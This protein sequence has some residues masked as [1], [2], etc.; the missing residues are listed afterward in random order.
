L[1]NKVR[2]SGDRPNERSETSSRSAPAVPG[3][4]SD[5]ELVHR[6]GDTDRAALSELYR[7]HGRPCYALAR[8]ICADAGLAEQVVL[9]VFVTLWR[10]PYGYQATSGSV[11]TWLLTLT[12]RAAVE[13]VR[14]AGLVG[15]AESAV[16]PAAAACAEQA[17][18]ATADEAGQPGRQLTAEQRAVLALAYFGGRTQREIAGLTGVAVDTVKSRMFAGIQRLRSLLNDQDGRDAIAAEGRA[19]G[20][21]NR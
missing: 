10:D 21:V 5:A 12:H 4:L 6:L 16:L 14:G 7:R 2:R 1:A 19:I 13:T 3:T 9:D 15:T 18:A 20:E 11:P 17:V 8:R